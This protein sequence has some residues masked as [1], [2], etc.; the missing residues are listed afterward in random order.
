MTKMKKER[1]LQ[2][3]QRDE[4]FHARVYAKLLERSYSG[5]YG[6][7]LKKLRDLEVKHA[8]QLEHLLEYDG[9]P[10]LPP[11]RRIAETI[12]RISSRIFGVTFAIKFM[13]YNKL[14]VNRKLQEGLR[15]FSFTAK[16]KE[17]LNKLSKEEEIEDKLISPRNTQPHQI[18]REAILSQ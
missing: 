18:Q 11:D 10:M 13:E 4:A 8:Q 17:V 1:Y 9:I 12:E 5:R 14:V 7:T 16:E 2:E 6:S 3:L 15:K